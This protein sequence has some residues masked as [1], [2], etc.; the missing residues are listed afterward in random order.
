MSGMSAVTAMPRA[1]SA[2]AGPTPDSIRRQQHLAVGSD[3]AVGQAHAAATAALDHQAE[4]ER[5]A[6]QV[7]GGLLSSPTVQAV[8]E[9]SGGVIALRPTRPPSDA[10]LVPGDTGG[11]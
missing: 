4:H 11:D 8:E 7:D 6:Q 9:G 1:A 3:D 5:L 10:E 2:S